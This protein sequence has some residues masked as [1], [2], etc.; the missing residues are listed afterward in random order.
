MTG[1]NI[2]RVTANK[3]TDPILQNN[4]MLKANNKYINNWFNG[5]SCIY[6]F[7]LVLL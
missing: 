4:D 2:W 3:L 1:K 5:T 7:K 6:W